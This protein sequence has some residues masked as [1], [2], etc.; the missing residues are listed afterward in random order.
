MGRELTELEQELWASSDALI[1]VRDGS[2]LVERMYCASA[3]R[4]SR[5]C[6]SRL[7]NRGMVVW[8][9]WLMAEGG[10]PEVYEVVGECESSS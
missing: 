9:R 2:R 10:E 6:T 8:S 7:P 1:K 3:R 5:R 4:A